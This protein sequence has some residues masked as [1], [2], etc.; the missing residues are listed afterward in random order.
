MTEKMHQEN[1]MT[2]DLLMATLPV[3]GKGA[4]TF[5]S[6]LLDTSLEN[7]NAQ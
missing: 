7:I 5:L 3:T 4:V 6:H 1:F 2:N